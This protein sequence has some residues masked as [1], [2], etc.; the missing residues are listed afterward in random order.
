[1]PTMPS[2]I[3]LAKITNAS[4]QTKIDD[5][6]VFFIAFPTTVIPTAVQMMENAESQK[7]NW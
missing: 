4:N 3:V 2:A 7:A 5:F 6:P 1:M